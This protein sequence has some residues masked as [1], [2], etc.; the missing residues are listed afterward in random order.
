MNIFQVTV[1]GLCGSLLA[2]PSGAPTLGNPE[3]FTGEIL[4]PI[5]LSGAAGPR[6]PEGDLVLHAGASTSAVVE[7]PQP[8]AEMSWRLRLTGEVD[9]DRRLRTE[10]EFSPFYRRID[11]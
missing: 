3:G 8:L 11:D 9:V 1:L 6:T 10:N 4:V 2:Q 5:V 7:A